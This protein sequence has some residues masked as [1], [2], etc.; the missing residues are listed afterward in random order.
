MAGMET[1]CPFPILVDD[2]LPM[3]YKFIASGIDLRVNGKWIMNQKWN[4]EIS[5]QYKPLTCIT[6]VPLTHLNSIY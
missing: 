2:F 5:F 6:Y 4:V 3:K 1:S